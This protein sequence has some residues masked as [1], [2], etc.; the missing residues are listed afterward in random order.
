MDES[1]EREANG[2]APSFQEFLA[3]ALTELESLVDRYIAHRGLSRD[4]VD[5]DSLQRFLEHAGNGLVTDATTAER[6]LDALLRV[7]ADRFLRVP[8]R[9]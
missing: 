9:A 1:W 6:M 2:E 5:R 7:R 8:K 4:D 3:A